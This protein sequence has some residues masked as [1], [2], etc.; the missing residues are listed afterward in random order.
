MEVDKDLDKIAKYLSVCLGLT[1][2][3]KNTL[4]SLGFKEENISNDVKKYIKQIIDTLRNT[5][6]DPIT[7]INTSLIILKNNQNK[8]P[9]PLE[10]FIIRPAKNRLNEV[11]FDYNLEGGRSSSLFRPKEWDSGV[12]N[13]LNTSYSLDLFLLKDKKSLLN[14]KK[15]GIIE[16]PPRIEEA[17]KK[18]KEVMG[19]KK[20]EP[21]DRAIKAIDILMEP[22][23][24]TY[25]SDRDREDIQELNIEIK[26]VIWHIANDLATDVY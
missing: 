17:A 10:K 7:R 24:P 14:L 4:N 20:L 18:A 9:L 8:A 11:L 15:L 3:D 21:N 19:D 2:K 22:L 1:D 26:S 5:K 25:S 13:H 16:V 12:L 6:K 23:L